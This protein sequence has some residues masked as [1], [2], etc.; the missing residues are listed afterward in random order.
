MRRRASAGALTI[1]PASPAFIR[2]PAT[3]RDR[4]IEARFKW[5]RAAATSSH[6]RHYF[7]QSS[8]HFAFFL[9]RAGSRRWTWELPRS[10]A[11]DVVRPGRPP[12]LIAEP[13]RCVFLAFSMSSFNS[14]SLLFPRGL[15]WGKGVGRRNTTHICPGSAK[16]RHR[17]FDRLSP[18]GSPRAWARLMRQTAAT[19][20]GP[21]LWPSFKMGD[22]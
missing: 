19:A 13:A 9:A 17:T 7:C 12:R 3:R 16:T 1:R 20:H 10:A 15:R 22:V 11:L 14:L 6:E 18:H 2:V 5:R 4:D 21:D 8:G